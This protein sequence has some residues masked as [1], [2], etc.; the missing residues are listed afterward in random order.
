MYSH[1]L[2]RPDKQLEFENFSESTLCDCDLYY[3]EPTS[4]I[5]QTEI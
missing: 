2:S 4:F 3:K 1:Y 5:I